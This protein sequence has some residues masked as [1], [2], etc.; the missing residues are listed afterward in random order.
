MKNSMRN[1]KFIFQVARRTAFLAFLLPYAKVNAQSSLDVLLANIAK[2]N[3]SILANAQYWEAQKLQYKTGLT[4]YNP[5]VEYDYLSGSPANAGSQTEFTVS[6]S[7][8]FPTAYIKKNQLAKQQSAQTEFKLIATRQ[9]ILLEAKQAAIQLIYHN[10]F[11]L[12]LVGQKQ[13]AEKVLGDFQVKLDKGEA[14][15][16]DLNKARVQLIEV[17]K[18]FQENVSAI[19]QLNQKLTELNGGT[20]ISFADTVY[21][22]VPAIPSFEQLEK[23]YESADPLLKILEQD[24]TIAQKQIEVSNAMRMPKAEVGYHYQGILGQTYNGIHTGITVPLWENKNTVRQKRAQFYFADLELQAH[25]NEHYF[26]I[27]H[28]YEKYAN[29]K[30]VLEDY[31]AVFAT[32]N[33]TVLLNKSFTAGN[34]S[35]IEYFMELNYYKNSYDNYL[36]AENEYYQVIAELYK[37]KL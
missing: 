26:H 20:A 14:N 29:L 19:N 30:I 25:V 34:I 33:N 7:F 2:N 11:H 5:I 9:D 27:K 1:I 31:Q 36:K 23:E 37:Y 8:D 10:K 22:V 21:P 35:S 16:L 18:E 6:Q 32:L 15:I 24:K 17:K 12:Q 28:I 3:K 13:N 4:P